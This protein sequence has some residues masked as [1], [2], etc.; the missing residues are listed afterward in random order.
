MTKKERICIKYGL[1]LLKI[2]ESDAVSLIHGLCGS[3]GS[4][5]FQIRTKSK[6]HSMLALTM[7]D[8]AI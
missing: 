6:T 3:G 2:T 1:L 8:Q 7:I 5:P 4:G